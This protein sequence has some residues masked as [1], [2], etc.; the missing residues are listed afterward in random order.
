MLLGF[1]YLKELGVRIVFLLSLLSVFFV[2]IQFGL[3]KRRFFY[4]Q[5]LSVF[6]KSYIGDLNFFFISG[7]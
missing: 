3:M 2:N 4:S 7:L 6:L 1:V 5:L